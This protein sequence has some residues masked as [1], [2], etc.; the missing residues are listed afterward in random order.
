MVGRHC[1]LDLARED[2]GSVIT[3]AT[4]PTGA[5]ILGIA[6]FANTATSGLTVS[7]GDAASATRYGSALTSL[8]TAGRYSLVGL[9]VIPGYVVG[10]VTVSSDGT[11]QDANITFTTGGAALTSGVIYGIEVTYTGGAGE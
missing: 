7:V 6:I 11:Y 8:Q 4:L 9:G 10:T 5:N 3:F 2:A 1:A